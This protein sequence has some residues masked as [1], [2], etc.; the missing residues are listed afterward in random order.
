[1]VD[2]INTR[3]KSALKQLVASLNDI[4]NRLLDDAT[5]C[6][7]ECRSVHLGALIKYM[8][9]EKLLDGATEPAFEGRS[10]AD[11]VERMLNMPS[12]SKDCHKTT[13]FSACELSLSGLTKTA[14]KS[15]DAI[16]GLGLD[17]VDE[18]WAITPAKRGKKAKKKG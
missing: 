17:D 16:Q 15:A 5:G 2:H 12:P 9:D 13:P 10:V 4:R 6:S 14:L 7:F 18:C 3:R 8:H 11:T 1:M